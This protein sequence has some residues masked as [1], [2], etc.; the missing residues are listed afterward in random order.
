MKGHYKSTVRI[1]SNLKLLSLKVASSEI[2]PLKKE[3][4]QSLPAKIFHFPFKTHIHQCPQV[5]RK[6]NFFQK[7]SL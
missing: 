5:P 6:E 2:R 3:S 1:N 4:L 7:L